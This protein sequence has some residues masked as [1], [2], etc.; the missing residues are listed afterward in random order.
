MKDHERLIH[1]LI[2]EAM[3]L[4]IALGKAEVISDELF[5]EFFSYPDA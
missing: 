4:E 2:D 1:T 3:G 5:Q